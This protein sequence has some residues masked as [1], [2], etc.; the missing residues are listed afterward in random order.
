MVKRSDNMTRR[1]LGLLQDETR[2]AIY[3]QLLV[4]KKRTLKELSDNLGKG[5][6][7][8]HHHIRKFEEEGLLLWDEEKEDK[9][10]HSAGTLCS[11][12]RGFLQGGKPGY[13]Q[14]QYPDVPRVA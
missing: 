10:A 2:L 11:G 3:I 4:Y 5:K 7:T 8:I 1:L 13:S 14:F 6:T 12:G 9:S